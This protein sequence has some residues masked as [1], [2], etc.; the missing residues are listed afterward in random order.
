M[1]KLFEAKLA[2]F[3]SL[4]ALYFSVVCSV[5]F[6]NSEMAMGAIVSAISVVVSMIHLGEV[7]KNG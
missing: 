4:V 2:V 5:I 7:S 3:L 6:N 1:S